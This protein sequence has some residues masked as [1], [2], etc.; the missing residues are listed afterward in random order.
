MKNDVRYF[1]IG[2]AVNSYDHIKFGE[3]PKGI[4]IF[5]EIFNE[6]IVNLVAKKKI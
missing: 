4:D 6:K 5:F 3:M 1:I 2:R